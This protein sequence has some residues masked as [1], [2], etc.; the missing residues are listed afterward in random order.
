[1]A[2]SKLLTISPPTGGL[3]TR[4]DYANMP[5][6]Q[7]IVLDNLIPEQ[8]FLRSRGGYTVEKV[9]GSFGTRHLERRALSNG[10]YIFAAGA[11][12][13]NVTTDTMLETGTNGEPIQSLEIHS[14][15]LIFA[16]NGNHVPAQTD[17]ATVTPLTLSLFQPDGTTPSTHTPE[18]LFYGANHKGRMW[19]VV[20]DSQMLFFCD[21]AGGFHGNIREYDVSSLLKR[22]GSVAAIFSHS[23]E[24]GSGLDDLFCVLS[25]EGELLIY[26]GDDPVLATNWQLVQHLHLPPPRTTNKNSAYKNVQ[27][28]PGDTL[29]FTTQ[30]LL[31]LEAARGGALPTDNAHLGGVIQSALSFGDR[32]RDKHGIDYLPEK[33]WIIVNLHNQNSDQYGT[34]Q[35][36]YNLRS[37]GWC[38]FTGIAANDWVED[39]GEVYMIRGANGEYCHF[40]F[41]GTDNPDGGEPL[42]I[43]IECITGFS[44]F[45]TQNAKKA[46]GVG[47]TFDKYASNISLRVLYDYDTTP[48]LHV[49]NTWFAA[50]AIWDVTAWDVT[51]WDG[52]FSNQATFTAFLPDSGKGYAMGIKLKGLTSA[53]IKIHNFMIRVITG[54]RL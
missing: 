3:N 42:P 47:A 45:G 23:L 21:T 11:N 25:T 24:T 16:R 22:G 14:G 29:I 48:E 28:V 36:V 41:G 18:S 40:D 39:N 5:S 10:T 4:D 52:N 43:L 31:H 27:Q 1:M 44:D 15:R 54:V 34:W 33:G 13:Y 2:T 38:R 46:T 7:A 51:A 49:S 19:Y 20:E 50:P 53:N 17:G 6:N 12:L 37:G 26:S 9:T 35:Y 30:G 32:K 8:T